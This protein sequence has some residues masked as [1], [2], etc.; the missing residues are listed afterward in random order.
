[1]SRDPLGSG[2][3]A[4]L[5]P[6]GLP[7]AT[8]KRE[9]RKTEPAA[10]MYHDWSW[11]RA[12]LLGLAELLR[13]IP[14]PVWPHSYTANFVRSSWSCL[15]L[16]TVYPSSLAAPALRPLSCELFLSTSALRKGCLSAPP[17][18]LLVSLLPNSKGN[19]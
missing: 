13:E 4:G 15:A 11:D 14:W 12:E 8:N 6:S 7:Q 5:S 1:M 9:R 17:L 16:L 19:Q 2:R 3:G 10:G 18:P